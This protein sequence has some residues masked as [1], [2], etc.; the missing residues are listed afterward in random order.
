MNIV[1]GILCYPI[2]KP[3]FSIPSVNFDRVRDVRE[4]RTLVPGK[5]SVI[6]SVAFASLF[7][8]RK[9]ASEWM[10]RTGLKLNWEIKEFFRQGNIR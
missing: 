10:K 7:A 9:T 8:G 1:T 2:W 4:I 3:N 6:M 5:A